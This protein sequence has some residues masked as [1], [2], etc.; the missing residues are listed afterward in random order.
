[1]RT[2]K[3]KHKAQIRYITNKLPV[4]SRPPSVDC[5]VA[6]TVDTFRKEDLEVEGEFWPGLNHS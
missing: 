6:L 2:K 1:M 4:V 5:A 3:K